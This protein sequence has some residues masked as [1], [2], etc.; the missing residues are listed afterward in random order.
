MKMDVLCHDGRGENGVGGG[1]SD[2]RGREMWV[3]LG[4]LEAGCVRFKRII[5]LYELLE[6]KVE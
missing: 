1:N 3:R 4:R 2:V 6:L 5:L